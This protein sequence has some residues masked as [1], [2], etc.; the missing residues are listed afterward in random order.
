[1]HARRA[2][3]DEE[4]KIALSDRRPDQRQ[5]RTDVQSF[6]H[7]RG[8]ARAE[9]SACEVVHGANTGHGARGDSRVQKIAEDRLSPGRGNGG[10]CVAASDHDSDSSAL[11][12]KN[13]NDASTDETGPAG[14]QDWAVHN[15]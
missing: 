7:A 3:Q 15:D 13:L 11:C 2:A 12:A 9:Q 5:R 14:D 6:V 1:M 8:L 4:I 10:G